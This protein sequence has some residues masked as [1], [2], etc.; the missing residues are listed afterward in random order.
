M[1]NIKSIKYIGEE[2]T[3]DLEVDHSDH[4]FYLSNG[5]LTS[6]SHSVLYSMIS[7]QTAYLKAHNPIE[8]LLANLMFEVNSNAQDSKSNIEKIKKELR[9]RKVKIIAPSINESQLSYTITEGNKLITGLDALKFVGEEAI[10]DIIEKRPFKSFYDFMSRVDSKKVRANNIQA[11][12]ASGSL[13]IF[14]I[15][16][17][18]MFLN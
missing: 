15:S 13:D 10:K 7:Y 3:Y 9:D 2:Q 18:L 8:F 5:I 12:A 11:L 6:N 14:G 16:R 17:K 1:G 4:Q